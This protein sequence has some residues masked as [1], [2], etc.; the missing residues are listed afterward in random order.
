[1]TD[2]SYKNR[3]KFYIALTVFAF[4]LCA[5]LVPLSIRDLIDRRITLIL[6]IV[7][8]AC[9]AT[10]F[11]KIVEGNNDAELLK[12]LAESNR[13]LQDIELEKR[14][15]QLNALQSQINPHFLYN[16]LDTIRG[17]ALERDCKDVSDVV[18]SLSS[19]FKYNM[20]FSSSLVNIQ[21]EIEQIQRFMNIQ[22]QRFPGKY[23]FEQKFECS[24]DNLLQVLIPKFTLQPL[25]ENALS[26]GLKAKRK[27][28]VLTIRYIN[29]GYYFSIIVSDNG[30]G[31]SDD[32]VKELNERIN[33]PRIDH[34][35]NIKVN[36]MGI[37]LPNVAARL[38]M[39]FGDEYGLH[40][41]STLGI[42]TDVT[43][44]MPLKNGTERTD[45]L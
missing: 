38:K 22:E 12:D 37:A 8:I 41:V 3:N 11:W 9:A 29:T 18:A 32:V 28:A 26:H 27:D 24:D 2:H 31:M 30:V 17:M 19:M 44:T 36:D 21:S 10:G 6:L 39:Y 25:V 34:E 33:D 45:T 1:M 5:I 4:V 7:S 16:T 23:R 15:E 20:D 14:K 43:V 40:I 35:N 42:G 13:K